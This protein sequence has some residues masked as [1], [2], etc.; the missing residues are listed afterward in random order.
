MNH[1]S[2]QINSIRAHLQ[3]KRRAGFRCDCAG[4][5][6]PQLLVVLTIAGLLCGYSMSHWL[7]VNEQGK[8]GNAV[9]VAHETGAGSCTQP[10]VWPEAGR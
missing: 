7:V 6:A 2:M 1:A 9:A 4:F 8:V 3:A 5:T 10:A